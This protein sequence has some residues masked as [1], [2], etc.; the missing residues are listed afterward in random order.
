MFPVAELLHFLRGTLG[1]ERCD[2]QVN[3][4][5]LSQDEEDEEVTMARRA[6][7]IAKLVNSSLREES[8]SHVNVGCTPDLL[9]KSFRY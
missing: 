4:T 5:A 1:E 2:D 8:Q 7:S 6:A 3:Q 9:T